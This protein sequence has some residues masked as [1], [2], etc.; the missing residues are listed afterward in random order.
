MK[1]RVRCERAGCAATAVVYVTLQAA[2]GNAQWWAC[3]QHA[4]E[5]KA[6]VVEQAAAQGEAVGSIEILEQGRLL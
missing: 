4:Q 3:R 2:D 5:F 1:R 6:W